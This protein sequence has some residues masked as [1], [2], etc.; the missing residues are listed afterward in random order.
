LVDQESSPVT[1]PGRRALIG[2]I[3]YSKH[4]TRLVVFNVLN[5]EY[6][7]GWSSPVQGFSHNPQ[8]GVDAVHH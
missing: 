7:K 1:S 6:R 8:T 5:I 2:E 3:R 4:D